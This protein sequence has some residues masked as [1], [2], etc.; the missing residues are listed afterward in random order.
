MVEVVINQNDGFVSITCTGGETDLDFDFPIYEKSHLRIIRTRAG[1]DTTL[2][3]DTNY[4]IATD[5]LEVTAGGTAVLSVAALAGDVYSLLLN[6]PEERITDFNEAGD[7]FASTLNREFDLEMQA[8]QGLRRDVDKSARLPETSTLTS[9]V[10]PTPTASQL[11]GWNVT[12]DGLANYA[13]S[14]L[15]GTIVSAFIDTLLDDPTAADARTTLGALSSAAGAVGTSNL[16]SD[17]LKAV[18][19]LT[20]AADVMSY[21]TST[22]A[23]ATTP[24]TSFARTLLDDTTAAAMLTTLGTAIITPWVTYTPTFTNFGTVTSISVWSRRVGDTLEI[25]G[26]FT[27]GT[28]VATEARMTLGFNGVDG[29]VTSDTTKVPSIQLAGSMIVNFS[30]ATLFYTL[31]ESNIGY[32]T[33]GAQSASRAALTKLLGTEIGSTATVSIQASIPISG[34]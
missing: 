7:L 15:S 3:L 17:A 29:G 5:Q 21:Y 23:A 8:I 20:P 30:A 18:A 28:T 16:A 22:T 6:A 2:V 24:L 27:T 13:S 33:F 26:K 1:V 19:P 31:I 32:I 10:L 12:A 34:W 25:R 4:T 11:I 9:L 14:D